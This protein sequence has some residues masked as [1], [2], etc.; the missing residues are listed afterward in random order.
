M[1]KHES[2]FVF[3]SNKNTVKPGFTT[4]SK[5]RPPVYG[6]HRFCVPFLIL[7]NIKLPLNN[8][9]QSTTCVVVVHRFDCVSKLYSAFKI[10]R[11]KYKN[12]TDLF[13]LPDYSIPPFLIR[14]WINVQS[15]MN[16]DHLSTTASN[17]GRVIV[18][19]KFSR[20]VLQ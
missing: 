18:V 2:W 7:Y 15:N 11:Y 10:S 4:T 8:D 19:H 17:I 6:D 13:T 20:I 14:D 3:P 5:K 1:C 9:Q 16:N 12:P